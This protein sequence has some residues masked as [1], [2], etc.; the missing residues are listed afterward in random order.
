[1][2]R[3]VLTLMCGLSFSGKSTVA[4]EL[5]GRLDAE[6][7][8]LDAINLERGL[9]GG[10]GIPVDEWAKT[11]RIAHG[12]ATTLLRAGRHV[13]IDDTGSPRF[14]RDEW[15]AAA[16]RAG[17]AFALVWVQI[18]PELQRERVRANRSDLSRHDVVD[19]VLAEHTAGFENPIDEDPIIIDAR[20]TTSEQDLND[21]VTKLRTKS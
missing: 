13:V 2:A 8:S 11:N 9:D 14:I 21:I 1:M 20:H 18:D 5:A 4:R 17:T 10:Q 12:R 16:S 3:V 15:R 7:I 19:A 6:L